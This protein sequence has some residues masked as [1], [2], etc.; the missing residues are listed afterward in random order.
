MSPKD[1]KFEADELPETEGDLLDSIFNLIGT[2]NREELSFIS[3]EFA[4][5]YVEKF[6][7]R[8]MPD[9]KKLFPKVHEDGV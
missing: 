9:Y 3:D 1:V 8:P 2:P 7:Y 4:A 6:K 5:K